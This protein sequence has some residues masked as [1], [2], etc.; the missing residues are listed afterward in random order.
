MLKAHRIRDGEFEVIS[1]LA[2]L[3]L[4]AGH[5][6]ESARWFKM[7]MERQPENIPVVEGYCVV[8]LKLG[9]VRASTDALARLQKLDP[10]DPEIPELRAELDK[11]ISRK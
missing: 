3:N 9:D 1:N 5:L 7:A 4:E 8:M 10:A 11:L 2:M 6:T